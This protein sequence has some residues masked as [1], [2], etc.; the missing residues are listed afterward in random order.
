MRKFFYL[1][2][3][4]VVTGLGFSSCDDDEFTPN[5]IGDVYTKTIQEI[6]D[7]DTVI[8]HALVYYAFA[9]DAIETARVGSPDA[10]A[11][12]VDLASYAD[13]KTIFRL[14]PDRNKEGD[15]DTITPK[16]GVYKFV[17]TTEAGVVMERE[18]ELS[19]TTL[20]LADL[21]E[22]TIENELVTIKFKRV[23]DADRYI[24]RFIDAEGNSIFESG[25]LTNEATPSTKDIKVTN[26]SR[27]WALNKSII[28]VEKIH[29]I[30]VK[31]ENSIYPSEYQ[32]ACISESEFT[33]SN[34]D[35]NT[36]EE[37]EQQ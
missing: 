31:F 14:Y 20:P 33:K 36:P 6:V 22:S 24:V 32:V 13:S 23:A 21:S 12:T 7:G 8:K 34:A 30:S 25:Y 29:L 16:A 3:C 11:D 19:E 35:V 10:E 27:G 5:V 2:A 15:F 26:D 4:A 28:D 9:N 17:V 1:M 37:E 18:N